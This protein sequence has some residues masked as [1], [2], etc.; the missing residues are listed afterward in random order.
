M[1]EQSVEVLSRAAASVSRRGSLLTLGGA[2][3]AAITAPSLV[4]AE[5]NTKKAKKAK[6]RKAEQRAA[7]R[8]KMKRT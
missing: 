6:R 4:Q 2:L 5:K 8:D 3:A 1:N 7:Q